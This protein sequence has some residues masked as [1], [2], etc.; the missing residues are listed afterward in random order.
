MD[1]WLSY[2]PSDF[3]LFSATAWWRTVEAANA[4]AWPLHL[5]MLAGGAALLA[6]AWRGVGARAAW[7]VAAAAWASVAWSFHA[8]Q[9]IAIDWSAPAFAWAFAAEAALLLVAAAAGGE[10]RPVGKPRRSAGLAVL[11]LAVAA[12]PLLPLVFG[13]PWPLQAEAFGVLPDPTALA[14]LGLLLA[15]PPRR[16]ALAA[17]LWPI[18][19][20]SLGLSAVQHATMRG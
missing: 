20:L 10:P 9:R 4:A 12:W 11:L 18:P 3:V 2:R 17:L 1:A 6:G 8:T 16:R 14:T 5:A 7:A 15:V 13:R 19:L